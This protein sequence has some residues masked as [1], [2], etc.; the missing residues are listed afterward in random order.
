LALFGAVMGQGVIWYTGQFYAMSFMQKVMNIDSEQVDSL[1]ASALFVGTPLFVLFGWL[2]DKVGRKP[3]M[4]IGMFI[5]IISYRPIYDKMYQL[6]DFSKKQEITDK[7]TKEAS[8]KILEGT[9]IDSVYTSQKFYADG[10]HL[11]EVVTKHI[12][13]GQILKDD[14]GKDKV[15]TKITK[16]ID[17]NTKWTCILGFY[18]SS[19]RNNGLWTNRSIFGRNVPNQNQIYFYVFPYHI[20]NGIF[21]GLLPAVATYLVTSAKDANAIRKSRTSNCSSKMVLEG[22]WYPIVVAASV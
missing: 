15:E 8:A 10:S 18:T 21:G 6:G 3:I 1:M 16:T 11:K 17:S 14:K 20:G 13:N 5:A 22:L 19:F 4:L 9:K 2:S 7:A 12:E